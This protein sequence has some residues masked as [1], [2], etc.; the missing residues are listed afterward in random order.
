MTVVGRVAGVGPGKEPVLQ[1]I[2]VRG[3]GL[4]STHDGVWQNRMDA[5]Y[6]PFTPDEVKG[7]GGR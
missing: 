4:S 7:E 1:M 6:I 5:N 2:Y 3:W